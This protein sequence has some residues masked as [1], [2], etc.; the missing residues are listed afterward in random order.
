MEM[1]PEYVDSQFAE[2]EGTLGEV[3]DVNNSYT[4]GSLIVTAISDMNALY[5]TYASSI[6][7]YIS[8]LSTWNSLV[9][10]YSDERDYLEDYTPTLLE[11]LFGYDLDE[12]NLPD[13]PTDVMS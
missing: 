4:D 1:E 2:D 6:S 9:E 12:S 7:S 10:A 11:E 5:D 8:S 3:Y 13:Y